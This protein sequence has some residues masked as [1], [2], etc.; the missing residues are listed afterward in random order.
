MK[1][2]REYLLHIQEC[3]IA[4]QAYVADGRGALDNP[5]TL[6]AVTRRLQVMAESTFKLSEPQKA[7]FPDVGWQ[8]IRNFRNRLVHEYLDVDV[9]LMWA[10]IQNNLPQL[11]TAVEALLQETDA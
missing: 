10:I 1:D 9:D 2:E 7:R 3:I 8:H 11:Q 4:I 6:D 5:M